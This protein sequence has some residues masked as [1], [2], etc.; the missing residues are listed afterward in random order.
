MYSGLIPDNLRTLQPVYTGSLY[1]TL[2]I[3]FI[4]KHAEFVDSKPTERFS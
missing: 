1:L 3:V 2:G 4:C